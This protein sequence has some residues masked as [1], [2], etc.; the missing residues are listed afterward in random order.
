MSLNARLQQETDHSWKV[1]VGRIV[2]ANIY[3]FD[4]C[5]VQDP[6][7]LPFVPFYQIS[8]N[9]HIDREIVGDAA[10]T[11]EEAFRI[12]DDELRGRELH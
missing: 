10:N 11:L 9:K 7:E 6:D 1:V 12:V 3:Y 8:F 4:K 5:E 2:V